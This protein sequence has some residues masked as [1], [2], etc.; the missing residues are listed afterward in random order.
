MRGVSSLLN[1]WYSLYL[2]VTEA[3]VTWLAS[4]C[5]C[6]FLLSLVECT[7]SFPSRTGTEDQ[8]PPNP[9]HIAHQSKFLCH[10]RS[11]LNCRRKDL[12]ISCGTLAWL[13][14]WFGLFFHSDSYSEELW[15]GEM[16]GRRPSTLVHP[17]LL[18]VFAMPCIQA[19]VAS[20]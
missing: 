13:G 9:I 3:T 4:S 12:F 11:M 6:H 5:P 17:I 14:T 10:L 7:G 2:S 8:Q 1:D 20:R 16:W 18:F 19:R 15:V